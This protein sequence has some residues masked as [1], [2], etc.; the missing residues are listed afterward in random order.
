MAGGGGV[1]ALEE[2]AGGEGVARG[3]YRHRIAKRINPPP[4]SMGSVGV[5]V[6]GVIR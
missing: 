3:T 1:L 6:S 5:S 4:Q 2:L